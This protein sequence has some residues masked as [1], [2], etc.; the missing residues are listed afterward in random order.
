MWHLA[1]ADRLLVLLRNLPPVGVVVGLS[2]EFRRLLASRWSLPVYATAVLGHINL[3]LS[4]S[5]LGAALA[6]PLTIGDYLAVMPVATVAMILPVSVGGWGVREGVLI[7][8]LTAMGVPA[9]SA[10]AFS[11]LFGL[12]I[13]TSSLPALATL[14]LG[15]KSLPSPVARVPADP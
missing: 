7:A 10:L 4:A 15:P 1:A 5:I 14:W 2:A 6:L 13:A 3:I 8:V 11:L 9:E 12:C